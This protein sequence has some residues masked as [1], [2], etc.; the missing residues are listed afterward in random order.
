MQFGDAAN[1]PV[2][3]S[4]FRSEAI[5]AF[6]KAR[7]LAPQEEIYALELASA[8][9]AAERFE[10]AEGVFYDVL[11]LDPKSTSIRRYYEHHLELWRGPTAPTEERGGRSS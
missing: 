2:A 9:D 1:N 4:S 7:A 11:Q 5:R 6:E 8:L 10:E 3:T